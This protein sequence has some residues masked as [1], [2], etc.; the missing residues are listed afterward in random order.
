[1]ITFAAIRYNGVIYKG[2]RHEI[3]VKNAKPFADISKGD[4]GFLTKSGAFVSREMAAKIA[5]RCGQIKKP[6]QRL[7]SEDLW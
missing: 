1:M 5:L 4:E 3:I 2:K 7:I 6:K